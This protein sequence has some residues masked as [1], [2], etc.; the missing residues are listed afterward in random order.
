MVGYVSDSDDLLSRRWFAHGRSRCLVVVED[1]GVSQ[2]HAFLVHTPRCQI[3]R[4][5]PQAN[6]RITNVEITNQSGGS[7]QTMERLFFDKAM[8]TG[9]EL[10]KAKAVNAF[11]KILDEVDIPLDMW[12]RT[13]NLLIERGLVEAAPQTKAEVFEAMKE[14]ARESKPVVSFSAFSGHATPQPCQECNGTGALFIP[15]SQVGGAIKDSEVVPC[16]C[17]KKE[18]PVEDEDDDS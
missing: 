15:A 5:V 9:E 10:G 17:Q 11:L 2:P 4:D 12:L 3:S 14:S 18:K 6:H 13:K 16:I 8:K 7:P 1:G